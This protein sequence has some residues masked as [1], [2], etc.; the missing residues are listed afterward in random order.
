[1]LFVCPIVL[2]MLSDP[3]DLRSQE[4][5]HQE[6]LLRE[7]ADLER[8][9]SDLVRLMSEPWGR[10]IAWRLLQRSW[11]FS[12]DFYLDPRKSA[13]IEGQRSVGATLLNDLN[14]AC[15]ALY[16]QMVTENDRNHLAR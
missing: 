7:R 4:R 6:T 8:E 12:S 1:M 11:V 14:N 16:P 3:I 13:F 10:R 2:T 15:P 5:A 9:Q